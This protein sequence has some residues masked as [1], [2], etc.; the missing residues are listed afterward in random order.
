ME[1]KQEELKEKISAGEKIIVDFWADW[2]GPCKVMKPIF[3]RVSNDL[4]NKNSEIKMYTLNVVHN[5]SLA[6]EM[7]IRS[8][9]TIKAF[10]NGGEVF[11]KIGM[12]NETELH[13]LTET[14]F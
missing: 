12:M 2:C 9:P 13:N 10:N 14:V 7:G 3:E 8:I 6:M 1:I 11:T 5:E 4:S